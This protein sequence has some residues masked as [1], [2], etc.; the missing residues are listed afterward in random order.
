MKTRK[1]EMRE[2]VIAFHKKNPDVWKLF[3]HFTKQMIDKG[4]EHYSVNAIFERIR[5]E[6]D[7]GGD[8]VNSFKLN[9][10]YRA[11]YARRFMN[12]YKQYEGF[13]RIREQKSDSKDA[14]S[15]PELTPKDY[16]N[17]VSIK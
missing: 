15:L 2:Q 9:N 12:M 8:G 7:V 4:Y 10:N 11:F 13:F 3:V 14:T 1:E 16:D 6:K 17:V 5:W